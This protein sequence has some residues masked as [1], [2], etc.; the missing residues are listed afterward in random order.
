VC[1][2]LRSMLCIVGIYILCT[3]LC[4]VGAIVVLCTVGAIVCCCVL[5]L[6]FCVC[7]CVC[8]CIVCEPV[9]VLAQHVV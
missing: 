6:S 7:V 2:C 8:V 3:I 5:C 4:T 9:F 1:L